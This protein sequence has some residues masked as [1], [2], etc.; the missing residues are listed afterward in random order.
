MERVTCAGLPDCL[1]LSNDRIDVVVPTTVGP[2]IVR[3]GLLG[4]PNL[5]GEYP[6]L[7]TSTPL[8]EW[9]PWGGHRLWA[10][11]E[12]M[13]GSY[14]PDNAPVEFEVRDAR[15][16]CVRQERDASGLEKALVIHLPVSGG[17][18]T[19]EHE[20]CNRHF[21]PIEI[22]P[23]ALT[24]VSR[25]ATALLP[26]PRF[27]SHDEQLRPVRGMA[28]W[29]FTDMSDRRWR[30]GKRL[31]TLTPDETRGEPQKI[32]VCN[33]R[34]WCA[35]VWPGIL[36]IKQ[37]AY[38]PAARYPDFGVNNEV[39]VDG[40]YLEIETLGPLER[41][42][43]GQCARLVERWLISEGIDSRILADES[44]LY[45]ACVQLLGDSSS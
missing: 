31:I 18:V 15:T 32:G 37:F 17:R 11:P 26:Q 7:A 13:P 27:R 28:L 40:P 19:I 21:W 22:A 3:C 24:V 34:G 45:D 25:G 5:M 36:L 12:Q 43:P 20:I 44:R 29:S 8:G 1:R 23:W 39:Y 9:K 16:V 14:A 2:R 33:E 38:D 42:E 35:C 4:G 6:E 10:A 30:F 41:L